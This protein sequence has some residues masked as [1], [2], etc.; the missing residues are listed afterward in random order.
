MYSVGDA[1]NH[2]A[3]EGFCRGLVQK[4]IG[5]ELTPDCIIVDNFELHNELHVRQARSI[6][7]A[8]SS[9]T[10]ILLCTVD[11]PEKID[12]SFVRK[13]NFKFEEISI[14]SLNRS[15]MRMLVRQHLLTG[16]SKLVE[17][18]AVQKLVDHLDTLNLPRT[19][20]NC[21]T[22]LTIFNHQIESSPVNRTEVIETFLQILFSTMQGI[23]KYSSIPD[24][25]DSLF[26][27]GY[28]CEELV[29]RGKFDFSRRDFFDIVDKYCRDQM[30][31]IEIDTLFLMLVASHLFLR[32]DE[33]YNSDLRIGF[34]SF[35]L[36]GCI[37]VRSSMRI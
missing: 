32:E 7:T 17:D 1:P 26:A 30:V 21:L 5:L 28:L 27:L 13:V 24:L 19:A 6:A 16:S 34:T 18:S 8:F 23:P 10:I 35:V 14:W 15:K 36:I 2:E 20:H 31:D 37:T 33:A 22:L 29:R 9:A 3:I 12:S 4:T 11:N 25:K